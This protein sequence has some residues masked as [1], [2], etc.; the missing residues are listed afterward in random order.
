MVFVSIKL[1]LVLN[2]FSISFG[3]V[4]ND[5]YLFL[6]K[7]VSPQS[8][9]CQERHKKLFTGND[10]FGIVLNGLWKTRANYLS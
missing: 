2:S 4:K 10:K 3:G 9:I 7:F 6:K 1:F 5:F 8:A